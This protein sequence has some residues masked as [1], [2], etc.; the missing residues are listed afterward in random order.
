[1]WQGELGK[2]PMQWVDCE[3]QVRLGGASG[4][5]ASLRQCLC[6]AR[7]SFRHFLPSAWEFDQ[8][9]LFGFIHLTRLV[10]F[11]LR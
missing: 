9:Q 10:C 8:N 11:V 3:G 4:P 7:L 5:S 1:M 6:R 2:V